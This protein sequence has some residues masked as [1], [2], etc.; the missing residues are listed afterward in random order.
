MLI[1][2][3]PFVAESFAMTKLHKDIAMRLMECVGD[4]EYS[5]QAVVKVSNRVEKERERERE[6]ERDELSFAK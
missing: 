6:K 3:V 4:E 2:F 5:D 1:G